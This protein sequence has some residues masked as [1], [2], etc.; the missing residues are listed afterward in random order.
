MKLCTVTEG[1]AAVSCRCD[2]LVVRSR[3]DYRPKG[4]GGMHGGL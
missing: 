2:L 4:T 3:L 1:D